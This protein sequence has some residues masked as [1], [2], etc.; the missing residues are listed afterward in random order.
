M[1]AW[2]WTDKIPQPPEDVLQAAGNPRLRPA[3]L[4]SLGVIDAV[5]GA[6]FISLLMLL[7]LL[8][9]AEEAVKRALGTKEERER[10]RARKKEEDK[11][12]DAIVARQGLDKVFDGNGHGAAGQSLP[13][14]YGHS[15]HHQRLLLATREGMDRPGRSAAARQRGAGEAPA[16]RRPSSRRRSGP[17]RQPTGPGLPGA[18]LAR[19]ASAAAP[20]RHRALA[21]TCSGRPSPARRRSARTCRRPWSGSRPC[22]P[23]RPA[24]SSRPW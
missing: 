1:V 5:L 22:R 4:P 8:S 15:P 20:G 18:R 17:R 6:P 7:S 3:V 16:D 10:W 12:R 9:D 23:G 14:R 2:C 13:R 21:L 24:W 11:H 19:P